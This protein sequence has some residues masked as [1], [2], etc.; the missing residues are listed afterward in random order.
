VPGAL[1]GQSTQPVEIENSNPFMHD[2]ITETAFIPQTDRLLGA[3]LHEVTP[4]STRQT[5]PMR[6]FADTIPPDAKLVVVT[7]ANAKPLATTLETPAVKTKDD[8]G[9]GEPTDGTPTADIATADTGRMAAIAARKAEAD[10]DAEAEAT[11]DAAAEAAIA[12]AR[13]ELATTGEQLPITDVTPPAG[14][15]PADAKPE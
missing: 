4:G 1:D 9:A 12:S 5:A 6:A 3:K 8:A 2:E 11:A 14:T 13:R 15:K 7:E 10:A